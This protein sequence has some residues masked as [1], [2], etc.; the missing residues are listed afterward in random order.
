MDIINELNKIKYA[1]IEN[2]RINYNN[3]SRYSISKVAK[4]D[5]VEI[6]SSMRSSS[7]RLI[8]R[9][10]ASKIAFFNTIEYIR[11]DVLNQLFKEAEYQLKLQLGEDLI[12]D[13]EERKVTFI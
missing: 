9:Y 10:N 4:L 7:V 12:V 8:Y 11:D 1:N 5:T 13:I 6:C 3:T 2:F